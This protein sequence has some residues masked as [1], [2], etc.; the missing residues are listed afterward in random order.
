MNAFAKIKL[1]SI[2]KEDKIMKKFF[3]EWWSLFAFALFVLIFR[4]FILSPVLVDGHSMDP[5]LADGQRML[6]SKVSKIH[7][8]NIIVSIE[9]D[10]KIIKRVIGLPGDTVSFYKDKLTINGKKYSESYL[11]EYQKLWKKNKLKTTYSYSSAFQEV[12]KK[13]AAFTMNANEESEFTIKVP[14]KYYLLLGDNR[15]VS[16]DGRDPS[17]GV[18]PEDDIQGVTKFTFWPPSRIGFV[19]K[20]SD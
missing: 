14:L 20:V 19:K 3:K 9:S 15:L 17:V 6:M 8:F 18:I 16:K 1:K 5:T 4:F 10:K 2:G 13:A 11:D 12:A 7:R